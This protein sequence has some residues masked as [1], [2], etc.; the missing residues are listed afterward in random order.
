MF[1]SDSTF[2]PLGDADLFRRYQSKPDGESYRRLVDRHLPLVWSTARRL[3]NGDATLAEDVTQIV[4]TDFARKAP[5]L[6]PET[7]AA[8]WL[9]RHTCFTARKLVRTEVRRRTREHTAAQLQLDDA[10]TI[11]PNPLWLDAAP[12]VDAALDQLPRP[13]REALLLRFWQQQDHRSIGT[14][15]GSTEDAARKRIARALE[16]LRT[17]LRRRGVL[18]PAALLTQCLTDHATAAVP[19]TLAATLPGAAWRQATASGP[20]TAVSRSLLRRFWPA[21][22]AALVVTGGLWTA[23]SGGWFSNAPPPATIL[24]YKSDVKSSSTTL[25][26]GIPLHFTLADLPAKHLSLRLLTYQSDGNDSALFK[27]VQN[28]VHTDGEVLEFTTFAHP[29]NKAKFEKIHNHPLHQT[30]QWDA[31]L[32][33]AIPVETH[34]K[35]LGT[36]LEAVARLSDDGLISL[37]WRLNHFHSEPELHAWPVSLEASGGDPDRSIKIEDFHSSS[38][39]G[40]SENL[41]PAVPQLLM[42]QYLAA[43]VFPDAEP[44]PRTLLLFV[45]LTPP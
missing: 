15:L 29:G 22:A 26:Q 35:F 9:H 7:V 44:E 37:A 11:E 12:L 23:V 40:Q 28:L 14:A 13:D 34:Q 36:T 6:P 21:A 30:W 27:E 33:C 42:A 41:Q 25:P 16:K 45:T 19:S 5:A 8:G 17:L 43:P 39:N 10:M 4:F 1:P 24:S 20:I 38:A 3:V 18:L 32:N 31:E 2:S